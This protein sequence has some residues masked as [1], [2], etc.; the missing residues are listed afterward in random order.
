MPGARLLCAGDGTLADTERLHWQAYRTVL[1]EYGVD[2]GL[3]EY[4]RHFIAADGG[5]EYAVRAYALPITPT[6]VRARSGMTPREIPENG[7][8]SRLTIPSASGTR[9]ISRWS[10][11]ACGSG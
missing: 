11:R 6:E 8:W 7:R 9:S 5:P 4:R 10:A 2:M 3:E 1:L